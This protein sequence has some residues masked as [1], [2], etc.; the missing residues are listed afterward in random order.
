MIIIIVEFLIKLHLKL[1][2]D[3]I[4]LLLLKKLIK[5]YNTLHLKTMSKP[6]YKIEKFIYKNNKKIFKMI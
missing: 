2:L 1:K 5:A 6:I 4:L 3:K